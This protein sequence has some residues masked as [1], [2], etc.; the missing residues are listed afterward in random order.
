MGQSTQAPEDSV[1]A[2][3]RMRDPD[4][5]EGV[6]GRSKGILSL[7]SDT[8]RTVVSPPWSVSVGSVSRKLANSKLLLAVFWRNLYG[9]FRG[10]SC[11]PIQ[12]LV[13][14]IYTVVL[15]Y[16]SVREN[17]RERAATSTENTPSP[18]A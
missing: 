12:F 3:S 17:E 10:W 4:R 7:E 13:L 9:W 14:E 16:Y 5:E 8:T 11:K 18:L 2:K 15:Q 1:Q 6:I